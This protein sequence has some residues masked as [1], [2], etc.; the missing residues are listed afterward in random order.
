MCPAPQKKLY[1]LIYVCR[2]NHRNYVQLRGV[3]AAGS[4]ARICLLILLR[5]CATPPPQKK[6][7]HRKYVQSRAPQQLAG[8]TLDGLLDNSA[9]DPPQI[10]KDRYAVYLLYW[11]ESTNTDAGVAQLLG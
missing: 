6:Q 8:N 7:N 9:K 4:D 3:S 1:T 5:I 2:Q 11:Y 10:E